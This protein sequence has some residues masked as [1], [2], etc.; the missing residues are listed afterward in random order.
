MSNR[1]LDT[2]H[3][4][5]TVP[6]ID[7]GLDPVI[8]AASPQCTEVEACAIATMFDIYPGA[9]LDLGSERDRTF[10]LHDSSGA[11]RAVM[12]VSNS[13]EDPATLDMEAAAAFHACL[14][15]PSLPIA[16]PWTVPGGEGHRA[17]WTDGDSVHWVRMYDAISGHGKRPAT[18]LTD[19]ALVDWG[20][21]TARLGRALRSFIHPAA[22]RT[23]PWDVQHTLTCRPMVRSISDPAARALVTRTLNRFE[24]NVLPRWPMLRAQ[25]VHGDLTTDNAIVDDNGPVSYTHLTLPTNREV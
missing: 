4:Q 2:V 14:V 13:Q 16:L 24:S 22:I 9:A 23:M 8:L 20:T 25:V 21:V 17:R 6:V 7:P 15:D 10:L 12:K 1:I 5:L 18:E 11:A 3:D 19:E